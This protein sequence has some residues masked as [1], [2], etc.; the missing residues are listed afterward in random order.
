MHMGNRVSNTLGLGFFLLMGGIALLSDPQCKC[1]C[2]SL[3][4]HLIKAGVGL[5]S[6]TAS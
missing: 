6:G 5:L 2:R 3:A 4:E 1:G